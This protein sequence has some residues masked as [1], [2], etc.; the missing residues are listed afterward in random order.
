MNWAAGG[1]ASV[2]GNLPRSHNAV[3]EYSEQDGEAILRTG[4]DSSGRQIA[5]GEKAWF[6][7]FIALPELPY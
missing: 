3:Y 4:H 6:I 7:V 1:M 5:K 2:T